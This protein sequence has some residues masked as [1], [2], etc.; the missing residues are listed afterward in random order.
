MKPT[1]PIPNLRENL[2]EFRLHMGWPA[3]CRQDD[4]EPGKLTLCEGSRPRPCCLSMALVADG[5]RR[6][7]VAS[8]RNW[9]SGENEPSMRMRY[10]LHMLFRRHQ[11][12]QWR[13]KR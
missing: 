11:W 9:E 5:K 2:K 12:R 8:I 1:D 6:P 4:E 3:K 7:C 10:R 13:R